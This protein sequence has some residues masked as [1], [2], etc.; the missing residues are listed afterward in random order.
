[1]QKTAGARATLG[2]AIFYMVINIGSL[3]GAAPVTSS[4][5]ATAR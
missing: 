1:V 3:F 4:G 2:F 5:G